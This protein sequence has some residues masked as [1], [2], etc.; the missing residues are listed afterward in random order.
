MGQNVWFAGFFGFWNCRWGIVDLPVNMCFVFCCIVTVPVIPVLSCFSSRRPS[1]SRMAPTT[2]IETVTVT[3]P[4]KVS[5]RLLLFYV[6][7]KSVFPISISNEHGRCRLHHCVLDRS[8]LFLKSFL[9]LC[10]STGSESPFLLFSHRIFFA[11]SS[12]N[13][14]PWS[15]VVSCYRTSL[16]IC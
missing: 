3:R 2:T 13:F 10:H 7:I 9:L 4:L 14:R 11:V 8:L 5:W 15:L 12:Q 16:S 6:T 1:E